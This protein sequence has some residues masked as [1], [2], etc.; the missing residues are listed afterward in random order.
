M[1]CI[2]PKT[3]MGRVMYATKGFY[4]PCS[5]CHQM[6]I[7]VLLYVC[8]QRECLLYSVC[9]QRILWA[10]LCVSPKDSMGL[11]LCVTKGSYGAIRLEESSMNTYDA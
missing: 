9:H 6:F 3:S 5:V 8:Y 2:L 11:T 4:G 1:L 10:L 7:S